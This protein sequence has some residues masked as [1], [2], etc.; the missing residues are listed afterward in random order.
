[1]TNADLITRSLRLIGVL[2]EVETAS[3]EQGASALEVLNDLMADWAQEGID[4]QYFE[5]NDLTAETPIPDHARAAVRYFLAFALAPEYGRQVSQEMNAAGDKFYSRLVRDA[6]IQNRVES[7]T[8]HI[9][10][11]YNYYDIISG[12]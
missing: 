4:L 7:D 2:N 3:A 8:R 10:T 11:G 1:M 12:S 5:Q 6:V 9:G